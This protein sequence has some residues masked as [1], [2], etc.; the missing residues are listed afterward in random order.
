MPKRNKNNYTPGQADG[1]GG[2]TSVAIT[3]DEQKDPNWFRSEDMSL[4]QLFL[5]TDS[6]YNIVSL[7]GEQGICQFRDLNA[8]VNAFQRKFVNEVRRC[9]HIEETI[10][11]WF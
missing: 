11:E 5:Q 6:T 10:G 7:L 9:V 2:Q 1:N 4:C 3:E 8:N